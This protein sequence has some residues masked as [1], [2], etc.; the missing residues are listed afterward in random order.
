MPPLSEWDAARRQR[1]R[2]YTQLL[3]ASGLT[4]TGKITLLKTLPHAHHIYHQYVVRA[5]KRDQLRA[6]LAEH[7]VGTEIYYPLPLHLQKC[8]A[9]LGYVT[10]DLPEAE[11]AAADVLALPMFAELRDEEQQYV[12][13]CIAGFYS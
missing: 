4:R 8:F 3:Q 10:G 5:Q 9:W 6:F 2:T 7:G 12:V 13:E 1:A 11:R